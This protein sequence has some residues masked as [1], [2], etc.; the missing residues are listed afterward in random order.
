MGLTETV[1]AR[2]ETVRLAQR[3]EGSFDCFATARQGYCDQGQCL[4]RNECLDYS[5]RVR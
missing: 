4:Y 1:L 2:V 5:Q 3:Q